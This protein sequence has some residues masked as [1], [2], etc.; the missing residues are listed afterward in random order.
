MRV[1][2]GSLLK[3]AIRVSGAL[4]RPEIKTWPS[5]ADRSPDL[6]QTYSLALILGLNTAKRRESQR[7]EPESFV[8]MNKCC[9]VP[10]CGTVPFDSKVNRHSSY[11]GNLVS[12]NN[13]YFHLHKSVWK[14]KSPTLSTWCEYMFLFHW[15][16][17]PKLY[18]HCGSRRCQ[19]A[20]GFTM[21]AVL[22]E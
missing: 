13:H 19:G 6:T 12:A 20:S 9:Q 17:N 14:W 2:V 1:I 3:T 5:G 8:Y 10:K 21:M 7:P 15:E 4:N 18:N 11:C 16:K 22:C